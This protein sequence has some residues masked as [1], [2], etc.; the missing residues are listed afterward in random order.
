MNFGLTDRALALI[1]GVLAQ[2][3]EV[4]RVEV[5]G[6][7]AMGNEKPNSDIDLV[8]WGD[9]VTFRLI[10]RLALELDELPLPYLFDIKAYNQVTHPPLKEHIARHGRPLYVK[11]TPAPAAAG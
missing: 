4:E 5:F 11:T 10:A 2:Y 6:S 3:P 8:V 9:G 1:T 7:R